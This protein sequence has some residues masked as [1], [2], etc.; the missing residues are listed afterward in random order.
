MG[1]MVGHTVGLIPPIRAVPQRI[2]DE[3][4]DILGGNHVPE[5]FESRFDAFSTCTR[6]DVVIMDTG[7]GPLRYAGEILGH[8]DID[9]VP[10]SIISTWEPIEARDNY[11][12]WQWRMLRMRLS[13]CT[14]S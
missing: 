13:A 7:T 9:G 1:L 10:V 14:T 12:T 4:I 3:L 5:A 11:W 2:R 6:G 8:F